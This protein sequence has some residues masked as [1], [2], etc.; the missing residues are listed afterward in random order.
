MFDVELCKR[1]DKY[2]KVTLTYYNINRWVAVRID[3]L[4]A[5][6]SGIVSCY[7]VYSGHLRAGFAGFALNLVLAFTRQIL[8]WVR[9]YN[10]VEI[11]GENL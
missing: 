11:E 6:F 10:M 2:T 7:V 1:I 9:T 3:L 4:G 5:A 8:V